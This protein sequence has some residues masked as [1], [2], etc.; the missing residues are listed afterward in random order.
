MSKLMFAT[1]RFVGV[2]KVLDD[3][4]MF[5]TYDVLERHV[6]ARSLAIVRKWLSCCPR[7]LVIGSTRRFDTRF[8]RVAVVE[9]MLMHMDG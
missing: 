7:H 2:V 5:D 6:V 1:K 4:W 3:A 8:K 9:R